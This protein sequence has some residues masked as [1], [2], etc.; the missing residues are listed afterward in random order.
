MTRMSSAFFALS[1]SLLC[2]VCLCQDMVV[3][4]DPEAERQLVSVK[5]AEQETIYQQRQQICYQRFAVNDCLIQARRERREVFDELRR[6]DVLLNELERQTQAIDQINRIQANLSPERQQQLS[7]QAEQAR[8][9]TIARQTRNE[10]KNAERSNASAK[11]MQL[12]LEDTKTTSLSESAQYE[13]AYKDKLAEAQKRKT[14]LEKRLR[15][16]GKPAGSLP[17]PN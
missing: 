2:G 5:R 13:R 8:L 11:P 4:L 6:R 10:E 16:Q 15:Q 1:L 3:P 9:E 17:I 14:D 7:D 12:E